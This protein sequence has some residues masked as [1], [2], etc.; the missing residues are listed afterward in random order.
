MAVE[1]SPGPER[2]VV[3]LTSSETDAFLL[4]VDRETYSEVRY[5]LSFAVKHLRF[6]PTLAVI[7]GF[8]RNA[9]KMWKTFP[10]AGSGPSRKEQ[11]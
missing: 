6:V 7:D 11:S 2:E 1:A 5:Q 9:R 10:S 8:Q 3:N 4:I